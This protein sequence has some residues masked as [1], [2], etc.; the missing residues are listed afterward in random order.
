MKLVQRWYSERMYRDVTVARWGHFGLPVIVFPTAGGDA[1][2]IERMHLVDA[3]GG[4]LEAGRIKVYSCDSTAGAVIMRG[5]GSPGF[6]GA[7]LKAYQEFVRYELIPAIRADCNWPDATVITAGASVGAFNAVAALCR[8]PDVVHAAV[9]M[10]GTYDLARFVGDG[11]G[12]ELYFATPL[13]F[14]PGDQNATVQLTL[15]NFMS[16]FST[17]YNLLFMNIVL[18]TVP[19]LIMFIFFNRKIVSGLTA[20]AVKG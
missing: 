18:V 17:Q 13:Y 4:L 8:F 9:G 15:Y 20:G 19:P 2:E 14:L 10:S 1:E 7:M 12:M 11:A 6:R 16:Q 3:L 5:E